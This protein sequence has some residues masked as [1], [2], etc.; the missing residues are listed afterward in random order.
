[1][2]YYWSIHISKKVYIIRC[3]SNH[4]LNLEATGIGVGAPDIRIKAPPDQ[5]LSLISNKSIIAVILDLLT[6][7]DLLWSLSH[8]HHPLL[9]AH[10]RTHI[11]RVW[12][13]TLHH[14]IKRGQRIKNRVCY[15]ITFVQKEEVNN[16]NKKLHNLSMVF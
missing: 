8:S 6:S 3:I 14:R 2:Y 12:W 9:S 13:H 10:P 7:S 1:M 16:K 15:K 4:Y 5:I 11:A